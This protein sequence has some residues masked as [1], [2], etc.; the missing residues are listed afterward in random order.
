[1][2]LTRGTGGGA[3]FWERGIVQPALTRWRKKFWDGAEL[4]PL[5][6]DHNFPYLI[7]TGAVPNYDLGLKFSD[8]G[9]G[10]LQRAHADSD[11]GEQLGYSIWATIMGNAGGRGDIG[12]LPQWH[13][14]Y[15][16]TAD[17]TLQDLLFASAEASASVPIHFRESLSDDRRF[18]AS[19]PEPAFGRVISLNARPTFSTLDGRWF[20]ESVQKQERPVV[21]GPMTSGGWVPDVAH[22]PSMTYLPYILTGDWYFLEEMQFWSAWNIAQSHPS[23]RLRGSYYNDSDLQSRLDA[24]FLRTLAQTAA[25][26]PDDTPEKAYFN[27]ALLNNIA[28]REGRYEVTDGAF[29]EPAPLCPAPC[30]SSFWRYGRDVAAEGRINPLHFAANGAAPDS[31][32]VDRNKTAFVNAPWMDN[33]LRSA[34]AHV[35]ELGYVEAQAVRRTLGLNLIW[36]LQHPDYSPV[37]ATMY[38]MPARGKDGK[39][40]SAW[41]EVKDAF[42][43]Q[44]QALKSPPS[45]TMCAFCYT[46]VLRGAAAT[47]AAYTTPDGFSGEEAFRWVEKAAPLDGMSADPTWA[48][49]PRPSRAAQESA[50]QLLRRKP[51]W[52][53]TSQ[54]AAAKSR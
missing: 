17:A 22:Q 18:D 1:V 52:L 35:E 11:K 30:R 48:F 33:F 45:D 12:V 44:M 7:F 24:W 13:V 42:T 37:L 25:T 49:A 51:R 32:Q 2:A 46:Y 23:Y 40:F 36:Q 15:L 29:Y 38:R 27:T 5:R 50:S 41:A 19:R 21:V 3:P 6:I 28:V 53:K 16:Y 20:W 8:R 4:P 54:V 26:S 34:L 39:Y 14:A 31:D 47:V 9:M 10:T 43:A